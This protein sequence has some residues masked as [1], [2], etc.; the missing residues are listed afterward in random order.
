TG[1]SGMKNRSDEEPTLPNLLIIG[2]RKAGTTSLHEYLS[3]HPQIF[4]SEEKE[5][6]FFDADGRWGRGID[7]YKANFDAR[8]PINGESSPQY[9]RYPRTPGVPERIKSVLGMPKIIYAIRDPVDRI[10]SDYVQIAHSRRPFPPE[11]RSFCEILE[12]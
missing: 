6:S 7:W 5:L 9:S 1:M 12:N 3:L 2:A 11:T 4:M 10:L 8:Y